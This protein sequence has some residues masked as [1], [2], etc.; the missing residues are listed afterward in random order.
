MVNH[1][2][3]QDAVVAAKLCEGGL[4]ALDVV[5]N[6]GPYNDQ[7]EGDDHLKKYGH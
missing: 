4:E 5:G 7:E 3:V 6:I 1:A 2:I